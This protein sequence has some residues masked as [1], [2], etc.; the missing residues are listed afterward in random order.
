MR[1]ISTTA[2]EAVNASQTD[3]IFLVILDIDH[4]D[5]PAPIR[6][7]NNNES[8]ISN[9]VTYIPT[10]FDFILP[11]QE[12]GVISNSTLSISNV[13]RV[14]VQAIRSISSPP[15]VTVRVIL[16]SDPDTV[17]AG[18]F[19]FTLTDVTYNRNTVSGSLIYQLY[20]RDNC[21]TIRYKN[22]TFPGL[23]G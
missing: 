3:Q 22:N 12:D 5:L 17:E 18:P 21:G 15:I 14:I 2:R 23:F 1:Q 6:V 16:A 7:V 9:G 10:A 13:D 8:I 11:A 20:V 19:Q 4:T